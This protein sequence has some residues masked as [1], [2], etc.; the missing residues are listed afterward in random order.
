VTT[1]DDT[2]RRIA[3]TF[4]QALIAAYRPSFELQFIL[5]SRDNLALAIH[6]QATRGELVLDEHLATVCTLSDGK[7]VGIE[8]FLSEVDGMNAFFADC[9]GNAT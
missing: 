8:T 1:D 6:N 4:H 5:M 9:P 2:K 7:I 3:T